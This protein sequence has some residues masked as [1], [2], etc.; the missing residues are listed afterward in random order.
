MHM[1]A[2]IRSDARTC[3]V[4][5]SVALVEDVRRGESHARDG[6]EGFS[7]DFQI[8]LPYRG[9]FVWHVGG[10]DVVADA[11]QLLF[12]RGGESFRLTTGGFAELIITPD[13]EVLA[14]IARA[15]GRALF[16]H[17]LFRRRTWRVDPRL[18]HLRTR[19]LHWVRTAQPEPLQ[20]EETVLALLRAALQQSERGDVRCGTTSSRLLRRTKEVLHARLSERVRLGDVARAVSASPAYLTDLFRRVEGTSLHQYLT[21]LRLAHALVELPHTDDLTTLALDL[22][23]SSH[24]H[25]S[26]AFRR[27]FGCTPSQYRESTRGRSARPP[28]SQ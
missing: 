11:N 23:F 18:Q 14:E 3:L 27:G 1:E 2:M 8:A 24:S 21:Q 22:G 20:A 5:L 26:Y 28:G 7:A 15:N 4:D 6:H 12:V 16:E 10:E 19:F 25:F 17:P 13:P 9:L